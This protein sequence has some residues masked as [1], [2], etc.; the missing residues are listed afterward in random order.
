MQFL[1]LCP[2]AYITRFYI[3]LDFLCYS[4]SPKVFSDQF[5]YLL[6][7]S[8][9]STSIS[10]CS[11][12]TSALNFLSYNT[13]TF[14]S[15]NIRPFSSLH[16]SFLN[17]FTPAC[18]ISSTAF[19]TLSSFASDFLIFSSKSTPSITT[20]ITYIALTSNHFFFTNTLSSLSL[21]TLICQSCHDLA[22]WLSQYLYFFSFLFL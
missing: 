22:K 18:F 5:C 8:Y 7:S 3:L 14:L 20:S 1:F 17:I 6:L 21:S 15:L 12:I 4:W 16:S 9:P 13:Y 11:Q 19:I 10:W 2:L